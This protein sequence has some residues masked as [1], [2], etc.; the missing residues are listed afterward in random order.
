MEKLNHCGIHNNELKWFN[1][2]INN[3]RQC[4][5]VDGQLSNT[6]NIRCGVHQ[7]AFL[8]PLFFLLYINDIQYALLTQTI[9]VWHTPQ[10]S[11]IFKIFTIHSYTCSTLAT[12]LN[13]EFL[14]TFHFHYCIPLIFVQVVMH[15]TLLISLL[16]PRHLLK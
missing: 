15:F 2:Y 4:C 9:P 10:K 5:K 6:E 3:R 11:F 12:L 16:L 7:G 13:H 8:G 1:S 14:I